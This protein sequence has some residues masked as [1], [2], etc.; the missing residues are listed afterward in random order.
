VL[1]LVPVGFLV[2]ILLG[3]MAVDSAVAYLGQRQLADAL[4][5]AANDA[6]TAGL[7]N[8]EF[9]T[10]GE[11]VLDPTTV[12]AVAC[13]SLAAQG[14]TDLHGV[15]LW[16]GV[17]GRSV[18]LAARGTVDTVFGAGIPG[19]G[20]RTVRAVAIAQ[21]EETPVAPGPTP[22]VMTPVSCPP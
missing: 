3:V 18:E 6:A 2:L 17:A 4:A 11:V 8:T 1:V 7:S 5:A 21:A 10:G 12:V 13:A 9:Y 22:V 19:L 15:R 16:V 14:D 20:T